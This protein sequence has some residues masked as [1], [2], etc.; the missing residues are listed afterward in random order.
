MF[1]PKFSGPEPVLLGPTAL[2]LLGAGRDRG[3]SVTV[4][5][6]GEGVSVAPWDRAGSSPSTP[7][8][9]VPFEVA[10]ASTPSPDPGGTHH[11]CASQKWCQ[12]TP[13]LV[14]PP[15]DLLD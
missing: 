13:G 15:P 7:V 3:E 5:I 9:S 12:G 11:T 1:D 14:P 10:D 4:S 8:A 6:Q 2:Q